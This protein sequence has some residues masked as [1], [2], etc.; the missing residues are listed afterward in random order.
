MLALTSKDKVTLYKGTALH[1]DR[2]SAYGEK[3]AGRTVMGRT[4]HHPSCSG[5]S[6]NVQ[7]EMGD[8]TPG[9][10]LPLMLLTE[11]FRFRRNG[12]DFERF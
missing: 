2:M 3:A 12:G 8:P 10:S 9:F 4:E 1:V 6:K 11:H 7:G 5:R